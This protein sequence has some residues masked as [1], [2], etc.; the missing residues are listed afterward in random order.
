MQTLGAL[1]LH[2]PAPRP[3][4]GVRSWTCRYFRFSSFAFAHFFA[5]EFLTPGQACSL[6]LPLALAH[7]GTRMRATTV[8]R[9]YGSQGRG[10]TCVCVR[11]RPPLFSTRCALVRCTPLLIS[12]ANGTGQPITDW[13]TPRHPLPTHRHTRAR[14]FQSPASGISAGLLC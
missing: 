3:A 7:C 14:R 2:R 4:P 1:P 8:W 5:L 12:H 11:G 10:V 9:D 13:P 6:A